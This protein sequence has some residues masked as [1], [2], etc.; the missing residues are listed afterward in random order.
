MQDLDSKEWDGRNWNEW[1][2]LFVDKQQVAGTMSELLSTTEEETSA[3]QHALDDAE[4]R[5]YL[6]N[7]GQWP[8][9][10]VSENK[11]NLNDV[12]NPK[13]ETAAPAGKGK[14]AGKAPAQAEVVLDE[15]DLEL[16]DS[17][18]NN[19]IFGDVVD[20]LIKLYYPPRPDL[21]HP[22]TPNYLA[23]KVCLTG[24]PFAGKKSQAEL[25]K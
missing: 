25:I 4:L 10:L 9:T 24:Y 5:D 2:K 7:E 16:P 8:T 17:A 14:P 19:H 21:K 13:V 22:P 6:K 20:Q 15:A 3:A 1:L 11:L 18:Q 12:M 23:L